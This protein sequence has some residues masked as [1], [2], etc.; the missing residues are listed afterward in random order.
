MP[1]SGGACARLW[2]GHVRL[3]GGWGMGVA[4]VKLHVRVWVHGSVTECGASDDE[5]CGFPRRSDSPGKP[6]KGCYQRHSPVIEEHN[7]QENRSPPLYDGGTE[8]EFSFEKYVARPA[9]PATVGRRPS[10]QKRR[11]SPS[12]PV[13][14][15]GKGPP[16]VPIWQRLD[17][18]RGES[19]P[20]FEYTK[21]GVGQTQRQMRT[22]QMQA[23]REEREAQLAQAPRSLNPEPNP[24][25]CHP[26][27]C[28][29][30]TPAGSGREKA[31]AG[32]ASSS[33]GWEGRDVEQS[34]SGGDSPLSPRQK[35]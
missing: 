22:E 9:N 34:T 2:R 23:L 28:H 20:K 19:K 4:Y 31:G 14:G 6:L 29:P 25:L 30:S 11:P 35:S 1:H 32:A 24:S 5:L 10:P 18:E 27:R 21:K 12:K 16:A 15:P 8:Q 33:A 7:N 26:N 17:E 13:G 3:G